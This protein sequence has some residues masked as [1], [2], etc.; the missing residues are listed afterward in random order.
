M[1]PAGRD[2]DVQPPRRACHAIKGP[3]WALAREGGARG[4]DQLRELVARL[5]REVRERRDPVHHKRRV[6]GVDALH[7]PPRA[8]R[9][10]QR[11]L[12]AAEGGV[13]AG[14]R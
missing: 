1:M 2:A 7:A 11:R 10:R 6:V 14:R 3:F 13:T 9:R 4:T 8:R 12:D 5:S